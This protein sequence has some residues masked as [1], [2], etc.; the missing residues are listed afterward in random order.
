MIDE[1][2]KL[3]NTPGESA[4]TSGQVKESLR[5]HLGQ[6]S[7]FDVLEYIREIIDIECF[8]ESD[9]RFAESIAYIIAEVLILPE[10]ALVKISG[11]NLSAKTVAQVF[12]GVTHEHVAGVITRF[13]NVNYEIKH[14]KT[15]L[16]TA[17]YNSFFEFEAEIENFVNSV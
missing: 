2:K 14:L 4:S 3:L 16:R 6:M 17:L 13:R 5:Q 9:K 8:V 7:F 12:L 10:D 15:Y 11:V 1:N